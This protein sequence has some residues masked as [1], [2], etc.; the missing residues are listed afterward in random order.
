MLRRPRVYARGLTPALGLMQPT[1]YTLKFAPGQ[2]FAAGST[3]GWLLDGAS[4]RV[5]TAKPGP[6]GVQGC[7][8][9]FV[10]TCP[11]R[12]VRAS[13]MIR[14][15]SAHQSEQ[16]SGALSLVGH[17]RSR[18]RRFIPTT[19]SIFCGDPAFLK[20][21]HPVPRPFPR[22]INFLGLGAGASTSEKTYSPGG[23]YS[24][25]C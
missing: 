3:K 2:L 9:G 5:S 6:I 16:G 4:Q 15:R 25:S 22:M 24:N 21:P 11:L 14:C 18:K 17:H 1:G 10:R 23:G 13:L 8:A 7:G 19:P 20:L 12:T